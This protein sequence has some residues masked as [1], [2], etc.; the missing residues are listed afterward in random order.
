S[1]HHQPIYFLF[2][3]FP[4][5]MVLRLFGDS[6]TRSVEKKIEES[7]INMDRSY[8]DLSDEEYWTIRNILIQEHPLF[9]DV[10]PS[11]PFEYDVKEERIMQ[12]IQS[13]LH[14]HLLQD[15]SLVGKLF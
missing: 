1:F 4:I 3:I 11:P 7:N 8:E 5:M 10:Q 12:V 6:K 14:R 9:K 13:L 2:M 15:V